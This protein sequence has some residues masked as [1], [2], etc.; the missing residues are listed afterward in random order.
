MQA[1]P[2]SKISYSFVVS[3]V[4]STLTGT[5]THAD[6]ECSLQA[7]QVHTYTLHVYLKVVNMGANKSIQHTNIGT[8]QL[9]VYNRKLILD[10]FHKEFQRNKKL[11]NFHTACMIPRGIDSRYLM[12][13]IM[14]E[15]IVQ[16]IIP[17][18]Y[19][20]TAQH[21]SLEVQRAEN[22]H[23]D[24][25]DVFGLVRLYRRL[26]F[27][28][29]SLDETTLQT[30]TLSTSLL[31]FVHIAASIQTFSA[32]FKNILLYEKDGKEEDKEKADAQTKNEGACDSGTIVVVP[33]IQKK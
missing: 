5:E 22:S 33:Y 6:N 13:S 30:A 17:T 32:D 1:A 12:S 26:G 20:S 8:M 29:T 11:Q 28:L 27:T 7:T 19:A 16:H 23:I 4:R 15:F 21:I 10:V 14:L 25:D 2:H 3:G 18:H 31:T 9:H 24:F